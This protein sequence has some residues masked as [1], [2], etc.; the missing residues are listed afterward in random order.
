MNKTQRNILKQAAASES[1]VAQLTSEP[2][3]DAAARL[4]ADGYGIW[5]RECYP[6]E[7]RLFSTVRTALRKGCP[8]SRAAG[9]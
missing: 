2:Q 7:F 5:V 9:T 4:H 6:E 1:G 8:L 3:K